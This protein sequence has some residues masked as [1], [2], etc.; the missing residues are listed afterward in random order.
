MLVVFISERQQA[1][2]FMS[3]HLLSCLSLQ[4]MLYWVRKKFYNYEQRT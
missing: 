3:Q 1:G 4:C 2:V